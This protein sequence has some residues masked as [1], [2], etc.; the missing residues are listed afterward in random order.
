MIPCNGNNDRYPYDSC[1]FNEPDSTPELRGQSLSPT[2]EFKVAVFDNHFVTLYQN[3][4]HP[5]KPPERCILPAQSGF[6]SSTD[7]FQDIDLNPED[8]G[9]LIKS[10]LQNVIPIK[11][12]RMAQ[13]ALIKL[14]MVY[15]S[16][17]QIELGETSLQ[18]GLGFSG[19]QAL[20]SDLTPGLKIRFKPRAFHANMTLHVESTIKALKEE[21]DQKNIKKV[22][23]PV[24]ISSILQIIKKEKRSELEETIEELKRKLESLDEQNDENADWESIKNSYDKFLQQF[25]KINEEDYL[26][27]ESDSIIENTYLEHAQNA[28]DSLPEA[29][30]KFDEMIEK[31][32]RHHLIAMLN[33][34][35]K[36]E[37]LPLKLW[38]DF[39]KDLERFLRVSE[40]YFETVIQNHKDTIKNV[41][42]F[43]KLEDDM[44]E[45]Y[46]KGSCFER[47]FY[48]Y[49]QKF[50]D[51]KKEIREIEENKAIKFED[52]DNADD[53]TPHFSII[54]SKR[55]SLISNC[56]ISN[57]RGRALIVKSLID[58]N[59]T[60]RQNEKFKAM[61]STLRTSKLDV[62][63]EV[64]LSEF[65]DKVI[66]NFFDNLK[67]VRENESTEKFKVEALTQQLLTLEKDNHSQSV[68]FV[69]NLINS[70]SNNEYLVSREIFEKIVTPL[71]TTF[72]SQVADP[73]KDFLL[74]LFQLLPLYKQY[75]FNSPQS[76]Q[77]KT[78]ISFTHPNLDDFIRKHKS[79]NKRNLPIDS[80]YCSDFKELVQASS[81]STSDEESISQFV[82]R[83]KI[84]NT[85]NSKI[86]KFSKS[87]DPCI[88]ASLTK[89][90]MRI[91]QSSY[92]QNGVLIEGTFFS[93]IIDKLMLPETQLQK[94]N[95]DFEHAQS[96]NTLKNSIGQYQIV[97]TIFSKNLSYALTLLSTN[98]KRNL[99]EILQR[100][101][102]N[103]SE[104]LKPIG[105][106][107]SRTAE[108]Q[109]YSSDD[110]E[111]VAQ[112]RHAIPLYLEALKIY[113]SPEEIIT[114]EFDGK[115]LP[116]NQKDM[117]FW[118]LIQTIGRKI[119]SVTSEKEL[120]SLYHYHSV[121]P[122]IFCRFVIKFGKSNWT[123]EVRDIEKPSKE[124]RESIVRN[125]YKDIICNL[126]ERDR[127]INL[128]GRIL[129]IDYRR[130]NI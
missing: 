41:A 116:P 54:E 125:I 121:S 102:K 110:S 69:K 21:I 85:L 75:F 95:F 28:T 15:G 26:F 80:K 39:Q 122:K 44:V 53:F 108:P 6:T 36:K 123:V 77:K 25:L 51:L 11:V 13:S 33:K 55:E 9:A 1:P 70:L 19:L 84:A 17:L 79:E 99:H 46:R 97:M 74:T 38:E 10:M 18:H 76:Q 89:A 81:I 8:T 88:N 43:R 126:N 35:S 62:S 92:T 100:S 47:D 61:C 103:V 68:E 57:E 12:G 83:I 104:A 20:H 96:N 30:N 71:L 115:R 78:E 93:N 101:S 56:L 87:S 22:K 52:C 67:R 31:F 94:L 113:K 4:T 5:N 14:T 64:P 32:F 112:I 109:L 60:Y 73:E 45:K 120:P 86:Q 124:Q 23:K 119:T 63:K 111:K 42:E 50:V 128:T 107:K 106:I 91:F 3:R 37:S 90:I 34:S 48:N 7:F 49:I 66:Q 58:S 130:T 117:P 127:P 105:K 2:R 16:G 72:F 59:P 65:P 129:V 40:T 82:L 29:I 98:E 27:K 114:F 24:N 118:L